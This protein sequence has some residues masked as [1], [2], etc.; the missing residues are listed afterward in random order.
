M[1]TT[2]KYLCPPALWDFA[3]WL[4]S[5][6]RRTP[7][8][9][10]DARVAPLKSAFLALNDD[11]PADCMTIRPNVTLR[12]HPD[13]RMPFEHFCYR[14][15]PMVEELDAF[16][17]ESRQATR[18]LD[19]G[20]LH[21]IFSLVFAATHPQRRALAI[22]ASPIAFARLLYNVHA[23]GLAN[24][25]PIECAVSNAPGKLRMHYEWEHAVAAGT[26]QNVG[27]VQV[28]AF[29][30]D[31]ICEARDFRPDVVKIDVEG[32]ELKVLRGLAK[33]IDRCRPIIFLEIHPGRMAEE[34]DSV[35]DVE[36]FFEALQYSAW[37][38]DGSTLRLRELRELTSDERIVLK[39]VFNG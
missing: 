13:S 33:T 2:L 26:V 7:T 5:G 19:I 15:P 31:D 38:V 32:H 35:V 6:F 39:P 18:L 17:A 21:G 25:E 16:L 3:K 11:A 9:A 27:T 12:L 14:A 10:P 23:N 29:T 22:D 1:S 36:N 4:R 28:P 30:G 8:A 34:A 24:V 37:K 20:A